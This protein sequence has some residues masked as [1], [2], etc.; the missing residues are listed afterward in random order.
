MAF[1]VEKNGFFKIASN[2]NEK[3]DINFLEGA[4]VH[5]LSDSDFN[6]VKQDKSKI[7]I[8]SGVV[9]VIQN[10]TGLFE[11]VDDLKQRH[12]KIKD[13]LYNFLINNPSSKILYSTAQT[14]SDT[15]NSFDYSTITFPLNKH[16]E[17]Y[18]EDNSIQYIHPLQLP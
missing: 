6:E 10:E 2:E 8:S 1:V 12:E 16:W 17:E 5:N 7:S 13:S 15:L 18:C 4:T 11:N 14:Y 3:N 9:T